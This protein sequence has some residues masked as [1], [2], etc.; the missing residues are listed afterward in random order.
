MYEGNLPPDFNFN[1][2]PY[3]NVRSSKT[4]WKNRLAIAD[5]FIESQYQIDRSDGVLVKETM[6]HIA[7]EQLCLGMIDVFMGYRPTHH[8]LAYLFDL[9]ESF[10]PLTAAIFPRT[11]DEDRKLFGLLGAHLSAMRHAEL[12]YRS[13]I[14]TEMLENRCAEFLEKATLAVETEL[15]NLEHETIK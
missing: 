7:V 2:V 1:P 13:W 11:T 6:L 8:S 4:Y 12:Q 10:S 15:E 3:R 14:Y 9:C 5:T